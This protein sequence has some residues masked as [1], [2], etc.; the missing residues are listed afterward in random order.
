M[1]AGGPLLMVAGAGS[2][3]TRVLT[4][5]IAYLLAAR[6]VHPAEV[7]AITFT[8]KAAAEMRERVAA[9]V[10]GRARRCGCRP[11]TRRACASCAGT[12]AGSGSPPFSIY[13]DADTRLLTLV[14]RDLDIDSKMHTARWFAGRI[15]TSRTS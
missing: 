12:G 4:H 5:R 11:S 6:N 10:G 15:A 3:K 7:L 9:Q 13:D 2:G 14:T 1:H 8:N